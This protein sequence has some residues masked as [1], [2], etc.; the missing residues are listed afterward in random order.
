MDAGSSPRDRGNRAARAPRCAARRG[1]SGRAQ[2]RRVRARLCGSRY[3]GRC[4]LHRSGGGAQSPPG[5]GGAV[6]LHTGASARLY[7]A[8]AANALAGRI[9]DADKIVTRLRQRDPGLRISTLSEAMGP[10]RP[11]DLAKYEAGL[12]MAGLP[13]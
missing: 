3:G 2:R 13:E 4:D 11:E 5:G 7:I 6:E 9:E 1:R 8:V 12:R 10:Y